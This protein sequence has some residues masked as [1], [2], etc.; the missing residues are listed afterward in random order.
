VPE[1]LK[2]KQARLAKIREAKQALEAEAKAR[3]QAQ[4][5]ARA[6]QEAQDEAE[7]KKRR[8][9]QPKAPVETPDPKAQRNFT[10]PES[11]IMKDGATHAFEQCFNCQAA[12]TV[13]TQVIV[14]THVTQAAN[15]KQQVKP[16]VEKMQTNLEGALP[17]KA[18]ADSGYFSEEN[19]AFLADKQIEPFIAVERTKHGKPPAAEQT[20]PPSDAGVREQ[21]RQKLKTEEGRAVYAKRKGTIEPVFGQIKGARGFRQFLLRGMEKAS[22]EWDLIATTHNLLK[23]FRSGWRPATA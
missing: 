9:P 14:A 16:V 1:V 23:L 4:Q 13:E 11:R 3:A 18:S 5:A 8:G 7:G 15:D 20:P 2:T 10:D 17:D 6:A 21:M 12:A 19:I 22:A